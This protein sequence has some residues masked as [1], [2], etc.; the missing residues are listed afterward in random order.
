M[1]KCSFW[2]LCTRLAANM[3][4]T[5]AK[6]KWYKVEVLIKVASSAKK[7]NKVIISKRS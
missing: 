3:E 7:V 4:G 5:L 6:G 1:L 2:M